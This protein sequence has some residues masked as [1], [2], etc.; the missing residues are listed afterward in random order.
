[1]ADNKNFNGLCDCCDG[2]GV[3]AISGY[4]PDSMKK[5]AVE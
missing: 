1:M 4:M 2:A 3:G 5:V